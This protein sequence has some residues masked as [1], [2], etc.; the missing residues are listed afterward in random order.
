M[1]RNYFNIALRSLARYKFYSFLN[2]LGLSV[3]L[4][5]FLVISL[6]VMDELS[7]DKHIPGWENIHRVDFAAT[8]NGTDHIAATVGAPTGLAL[9]RDY[10][11]VVEAVR[12][13]GY[14][15]WFIRKKESLE[16]F[17]EEYVL[18]AD[19]NYFEFFGTQ[20]LYGD[21]KT[22]LVRPNT[23]ALSESI[24]K[25]IFGDDNPVGETVVLDNRTDYEVTA[26]Y[27]NLPSNS[28]MRHDML[29]SMSTFDWVRNGHWLSTNFNTY[30][31]LQE[32][33]KA[34]SLE[35]KFPDM[36]NRYCAPLIQQFLN[37]NMEE[38]GENGNALNFSLI[39]MTDIHLQSN[40]DGEIGANGDIK[41]V[42]I[43][44]AIGLFI[45]L[46]AC[47]NFMNLSTARSSKRAKEVGIRKVMGAYRQQLIVQFLAEALM[48]SLISFI[49]A[50]A[51][52]LVVLPGF[53][54]LSG[55]ELIIEQAIRGSFL[56]PMVLI[57]IVV[58]LMAGSYPAFFLSSFRPVQVLK[59]KLSQGLR[60]GVIRSTLVVFQFCI[61]II[62]IIGTAI[63][64]DQLRYVQNKKLGYNKEQVVVVEDTWLLR[65]NAKT[66]KTESSRHANVLSNT[67]TNFTVTGNYN[68]SDLYFKNPAV[69]SEESQVIRA[70]YVD[71][72][73][74]NTLGIELLEGRNFSKKF[75][76]DTSAVLVNEALLRSFGY[77]DALN[78]K[79][80]TYRGDQ[81]SPEVSGFRIV[82]VVQ[83]FHYQSLKNSILPLVIHLNEKANG[84]A[85]FKIQGENP[86]QTIE[87][88]AQAWE[89][90]VPGQPFA[91]NFLDQK[92]QA[93]YEAEKRT[94][95]VF[96]V[97]AFLSIFIACLG[98]FG[99]AAFTA[100]QRNKEIGIRKVLG[101]S[102]AGIVT[103]LSKEFIKLILIA[104]VI[105][106]PLSYYFME[107][108]LT[109]FEYRTTLK[110]VTFLASGILALVIAWLTMGS[111]SYLAAR[112]NPA[113]SL[114]DE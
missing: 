13:N 56:L 113:K 19:S 61:S 8:L 22:A 20:L 69:A 35:A 100:E 54:Q 51:L 98:L 91:Y 103:L 27:P 57:M 62:M 2:I 107:Q 26:V 73:F 106:A 78:H 87:H 108:W 60:S 85:M 99:L 110:P 84:Q 1:I 34:P 7:Y 18:S 64:F 21:S 30:I 32:G 105:A 10:P 31:K 25:K 14:S 41:Y 101:A 90:I 38:F 53:N 12:L 111:Q 6:F 43:F 4:T 96:G 29:L 42:Y 49:I 82:G 70:A 36:I 71:H 95:D 45:L 24:A 59:G 67:L 39:A 48:L 93:L 5:C 88:I 102:V 94:G 52:L 81:D 23:V 89:D 37:M 16:T 46:L 68:N 97:F 112:A 114:K 86:E 72:E 65:D 83:D 15:T 9:Q 50:Y 75:A 44:S 11:E 79:I 47:I 58:G 92:F 33:T 104:F 76:T 63:V 66:F 74:L 28:H 77:E 40:K 80:Y 3:G 17:K 55:K 109:D